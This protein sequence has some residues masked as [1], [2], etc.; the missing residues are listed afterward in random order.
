MILAANVALQITVVVE[1]PLKLVAARR[2]FG[3][4]IDFF[5]TTSVLGRLEVKPQ[6]YSGLMSLKLASEV[7]TQ[8][9][10]EAALYI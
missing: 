1:V 8:F 5:R 2:S 9:Y 6:S 4:T 10:S 3:A 7:N